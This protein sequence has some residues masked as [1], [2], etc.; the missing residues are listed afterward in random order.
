A[1]T[2]YVNDPVVREGLVQSILEQ[3]SPLMQ[4]ALADVMLRLQEKRAIHPL[5]KLLQQKDL[6]EMVRMRIQQTIIRLS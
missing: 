5:K 3:D 6:N 2:H 1:L 4:A